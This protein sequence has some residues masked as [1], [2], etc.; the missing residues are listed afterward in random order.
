[1]TLRHRSPIDWPAL[2]ADLAWLLVDE[3]ER[4]PE[5]ESASAAGL[6]EWLGVPRSTVRGW[7]DGAEPR[8]N[9][10]EALLDCWCRMTGKLADYAPRLNSGAAGGKPPQ[11]ADAGAAA[12]GDFSPLRLSGRQ[13]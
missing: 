12:A 2:L 10:G 8:H 4:S 7:L 1:M 6:A 11:S 3:R 5:R 9:D 13:T